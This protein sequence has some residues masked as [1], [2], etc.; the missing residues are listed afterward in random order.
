MFVKEPH[1]PTNNGQYHS[2]FIAQGLLTTPPN[3]PITHS[4]LELTRYTKEGL[5][6]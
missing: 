4:S 3:H 6:N 2:A 1:P 5:I